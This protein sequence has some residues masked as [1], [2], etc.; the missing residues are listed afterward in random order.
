MC[1]GTDPSR[2]TICVPNAHARRCRSVEGVEFPDRRDDLSRMFRVHLT[3]ASRRLDVRMPARSNTKAGS[4]RSPI[5]RA[6]NALFPAACFGCLL[7]FHPSVGTSKLLRWLLDPD[8]VSGYVC[9]HFL[10]TG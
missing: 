9:A 5:R 7:A 8:D 10:R 3:A 2:L 4:L 1:S 6:W